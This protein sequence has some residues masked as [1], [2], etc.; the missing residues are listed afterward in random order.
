MK[1]GLKYGEF[2]PAA[3][4][5]KY[6]E[7]TQ[8][9]EFYIGLLLHKD[10]KAGDGMTA[11]NLPAGKG[12]MVSKFGNYGNG[13]EAAHIKIAKYLEANKLEQRWPMWE[14]YVN[15]PTMVKPQDIQ[16]DIYYAV[17]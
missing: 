17:K 4:Y 10:L 2:T 6:D 1:N 9:T 15:D 3:A 13:D 14:L 5:T 16:T 7:E 12:V 8:E 11:L